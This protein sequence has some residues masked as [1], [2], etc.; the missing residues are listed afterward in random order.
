LIDRSELSVPGRREW[1]FLSNSPWLFRLFAPLAGGSYA[2]SV[3]LT[4]HVFVAPADLVADMA[5]SRAKEFN[6]RSLSGLVA[7]EVSHGLVLR[8]LGLWRTSRLPTWIVEGYCD[9]VA[10]GGSFPEDEGLQLIEAGG[11]HPAPAFRCFM[12]RREVIR[13]IEEEGLT[14]DDLGRLGGR[15]PII[16]REAM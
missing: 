14:L 15:P 5:Y 8:R 7:H 11:T 1:I 12:Y 2:V 13:L 4:D 9:Y 6:S 10:G 16:D 3:P